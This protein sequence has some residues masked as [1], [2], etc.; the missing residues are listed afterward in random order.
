MGQGTC[1]PASAAELSNL[2]WSEL[3][4]I[5]DQENLQVKKNVGGNHG[6]TLD[7]MRKEMPGGTGQIMAFGHRGFVWMS[8]LF[9]DLFLDFVA[10]ATFH[11]FS[12]CTHYP[13]VKF[14]DPSKS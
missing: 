6:R 10:R 5:I 3:R 8:A 9:Q 7:D 14:V 12:T 1:T 2:R 11:V 13:L 4:S